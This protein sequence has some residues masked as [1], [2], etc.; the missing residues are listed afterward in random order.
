[1]PI[2]Q[3]V[4][5]QQKLDCF[6]KMRVITPSS[7]LYVFLVFLIQRKNNKLRLMVDYKK[8]NAIAIK[9]VYFFLDL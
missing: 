3:P 6:L 8:L 9:D 1:M 4:L 5:L 7:V 2:N